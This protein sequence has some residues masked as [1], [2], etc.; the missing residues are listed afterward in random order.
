[1]IIKTRIKIAFRPLDEHFE[2]SDAAIAKDINYID[3][4]SK[5]WQDNI[6]LYKFLKDFIKKKVR[7]S[8]PEG[9]TDD[10]EEKD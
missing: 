6:S 5:L 3:D 1:M 7:D 4:I 10:E 9:L 8:R 2:V